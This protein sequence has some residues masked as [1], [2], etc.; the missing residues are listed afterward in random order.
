[1]IEDVAAQVAGKVGARIEHKAL[2]A[3]RLKR[4]ET[5]T[6]YDHYLRGVWHHRMGGVTSE[7]SRKAVEWFRRAIELDSTFSRPRAAL[8]CAWSDLPDY[9]HDRSIEIVEEA[10]QFD[11]TDPEVHRI[12]GAVSM[13]RGDFIAARYHTERATETAPND[14]YILGRS[15]AFYSF[16]GE[17]AN[18]LEKLERAEQL[19]PFLPVYAV[20][21][22]LVAEYGLGHYERCA[23]ASWS[24][25]IP[26]APIA[27]LLRRR[28][29]RS[30][31][32]GKRQ[33]QNAGGAR[34]RSGAL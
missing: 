33:G 2:A 32:N 10:L 23:A 13:H 3:A 8:A 26:V 6:A 25:S 5:M 9:D 7:H 14:A 27:L 18:A 28:V 12:L 34:R 29:S 17:P 15:A 31:T 21:E 11:P 24:S 16:V 20:E 4:P 22:R 19:D 30:W 1:M